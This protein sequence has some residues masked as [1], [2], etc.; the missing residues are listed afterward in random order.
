[1]SHEQ[2]SINMDG[3]NYHRVSFLFYVCGR[4]AG[5]SVRSILAHQTF[6]LQY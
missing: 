4:F 5:N 3:N 1:M 2:K 6:K